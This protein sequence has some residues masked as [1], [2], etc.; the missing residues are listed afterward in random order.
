MAVEVRRERK[1]SVRDLTDPILYYDQALDE[2]R[3]LVRDAEEKRV[4]ALGNP[5]VRSLLT[6]FLAPMIIE[7]E[8]KKLKREVSKWQPIT[9]FQFSDVLRNQRIRDA[10]DE[11]K[12]L[13]IDKLQES[14]EGLCYLKGIDP[15]SEKAQEFYQATREVARV[16]AGRVPPDHNSQN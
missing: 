3:I 11:S 14:F 8:A 15:Q 2:A 12:T 9:T 6:H 4:I 13:A 1:T 5:D 16:L 7:E 10:I